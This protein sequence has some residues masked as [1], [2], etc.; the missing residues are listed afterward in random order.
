[1]LLPYRAMKK[2]ADDLPT[3]EPSGRGLGVRPRIDLPVEEDGQ[4]GPGTGGMSV[5]PGSIW[6]L[7]PHRRPRRLGQGSTGRDEDVVFTVQR[8]RLDGHGLG[9]RPD[10]NRPLQHGF[11][12]PMERVPWSRYEQALTSTRPDWSNG[13][14]GTA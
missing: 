2:D 6:F 8:G 11:V 12:E 10:P 7:P 4:V 3:V 14:P 13:E 5:S 1:M 9:F